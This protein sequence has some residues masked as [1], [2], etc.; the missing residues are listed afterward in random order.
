MLYMRKTPASSAAILYV[1]ILG[2]VLFPT[3]WLGALFTENEQLA[4]FLGLGIMRLLLFGLLLFLAWKMGIRGVWLP[5]RG[6]L[7]ALLAAVPAFIVAANNFPLVALASGTAEI[8]GSAG[9]IAAFAFQ[10]LAVGLFEETAFRGIIFPFVLGKT[11]TGKKGRFVA[12]LVSS[13]MFGLLHLVNLLGGFS[14]G[15]FLQVGYSFLIGCMLAVITFRGAGM[16]TCAAAH[17]L[18]NFGGNVVPYL[19]MGSFADIWSIGEIAL[20]AAV[21]AAAVVYFA[22]L[23]Y[24][25]KPD[26]ADDFAVYPPADMQMPENETGGDAPARQENAEETEEKED[27]GGRGDRA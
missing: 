6:E 26:C 19:G 23:L 1:L 14:G 21:G 13:A 11:G 17:A 4:R 9:M 2:L 7:G 15:V 16:F 18:F 20:T 24:K 8:T 10:C 5:R 12:V 22:R 25:S 3:D 27:T